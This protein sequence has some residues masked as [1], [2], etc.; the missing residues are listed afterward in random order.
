MT[1]PILPPLNREWSWV[2]DIVRCLGLPWIL[3]L[4]PWTLMIVFSGYYF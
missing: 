1:N 2:A 4:I 3:T